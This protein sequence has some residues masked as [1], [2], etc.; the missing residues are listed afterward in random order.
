MLFCLENLSTTTYIYNIDILYYI[1]LY[2]IVVLGKLVVYL[3]TTVNVKY[4]LS[5]MYRFVQETID[6]GYCLL[7]QYLYKYARQLLVYTTCLC[8]NYCWD[9]SIY[10]VLFFFFFPSFF[11][12][13][14]EGIY[15]LIPTE[16]CIYITVVIFLY[17]YIYIYFLFRDLCYNSKR[18]RPRKWLF[19]ICM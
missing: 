19:L 3:Y 18:S 13:E 5:T 7:S 6:T 16:E 11:F 2:Y 15:Y 10:I 9:S 17:I 14:R 4:W 8:I 12:P 1:I